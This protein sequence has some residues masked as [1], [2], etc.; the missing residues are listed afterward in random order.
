MQQ[1]PTP[2]HLVRGRI[3]GVV[4][5]AT[6]GGLGDDDG[7]DTCPAGRRPPDEAEA[8]CWRR[9]A[10]DLPARIADLA[11]KAREIGIPW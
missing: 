3:A 6:H 11:A 10:A 8:A 4:S 1:D 2:C 5:C 7:T 9:R